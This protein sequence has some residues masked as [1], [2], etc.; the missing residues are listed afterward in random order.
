MHVIRACNTMYVMTLVML[1]VM[2]LIA[3]QYK[4][5]KN[6]PE[7]DEDMMILN[8]IEGSEFNF[9]KNVASFTHENEP[10]MMPMIRFDC[11]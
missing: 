10:L 11:D 1:F 2:F 4:I 7:F 5:E 3:T 8:F 6:I 9:I